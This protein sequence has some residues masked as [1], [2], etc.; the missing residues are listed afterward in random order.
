MIFMATN[1]HIRTVATATA[2]GT[3]WARSRSAVDPAGR[4][5]SAGPA[6]P[7]GP[8]GPAGPAARVGRP[9]AVRVAVTAAAAA[10]A[11]RQCAVQM[12]GSPPQA[13]AY[14]RATGS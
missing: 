12:R 11:A 14:A 5:N 4:V 2:A 10:A 1:M 8:A 3:M 13:F 7:V 9:G 6:G